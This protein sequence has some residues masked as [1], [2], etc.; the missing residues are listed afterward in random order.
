MTWKCPN[1][2]KE[3]KHKNQWH[4]CAV[5]SVEDHLKNKTDEIK[6][7]VYLLLDAVK[8]FGEIKINPVKTSIQVKTLS[9][10]LSIK[11]KKN[12]VEIEFQLN[13]ELREHGVFKLF[14]ISANR[15]LHVATIEYPHDVTPELVD[16]IKEAYI[17]IKT[18]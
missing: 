2:Q 7:I 5:V 3:F 14:P 17:L 6:E 8:E 4:S 12:H 1:C 18:T 16:V 13:R 10:F 9:T 11:P 15:I